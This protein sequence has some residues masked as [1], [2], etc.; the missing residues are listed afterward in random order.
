MNQQAQQIESILADACEFQAITYSQALSVAENLLAAW[1]PGNDIASALRDIKA[2]MDQIATSN[3]AV[4]KVRRQWL[5]SQQKPSAALA[6]SFQALT[7]LISR[8]AERDP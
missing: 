5:Q 1:K 8:L 2:M 4:D 3:A 7:R 6:A